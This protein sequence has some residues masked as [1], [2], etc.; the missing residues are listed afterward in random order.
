MAKS[1][2]RL[3]RGE[4]QVLRAIGDSAPL[5]V[6]QC[7]IPRRVLSGLSHKGMIFLWDMMTALQPEP[8]VKAWSLTSTGFF[9]YRRLLRGETFVQPL[10]AKPKKGAKS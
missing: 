4:E 6:S 5:R 7:R 9:I 2:I 3:N 8:G 1:L 10:T